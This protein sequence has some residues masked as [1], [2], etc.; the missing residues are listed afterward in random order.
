VQ[1]PA[2][3]PG[4]VSSQGSVATQFGMA[5]EYGTTGLLAHNTLAG[6]E[7]S[8]LELGQFATLVFNE[9]QDEYYRIVSIQQYVALDPNNPYSDFLNENGDRL[10]ATELFKQIYQGENG[11]LVLQTCVASEQNPS[12][13]RLFI[14]AE[15]VTQQVR[16]ALS[17][18]AGLV[19]LTSLGLT[20][21]Q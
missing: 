14:I 19:Q 1:Q 11:R 12:W 8:K 5:E 15:P 21:A 13:G 16:S 20:S 17:Q 3:Q 10:S 18:A 4:F 2:G 9:G 7:F 6:A